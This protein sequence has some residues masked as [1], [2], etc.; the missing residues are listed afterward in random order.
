MK[1]LNW[2]IGTFRIPT[3]TRPKNINIPT[4]SHKQRT[5]IQGKLER[6]NKSLKT[7]NRPYANMT[8]ILIFFFF[9][10][11]QISL[12]NLVLELKNQ[13]KYFTWNEVSRA[14]LN[15]YKS[16]L[17]FSHF[18]VSSI[19]TGIFTGVQIKVSK[20]SQAYLSREL[21]FEGYNN[22]STRRHLLKPETHLCRIAKL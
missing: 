20:T 16:V 3:I 12:T 6:K 21:F 11:I 15:T 10:C 8:D 5:G 7:A 9:F 13:K 14:N 19:R 22:L 17:K 4:R 2:L 1:Q 18:C